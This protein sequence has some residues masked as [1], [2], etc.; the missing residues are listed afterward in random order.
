M[1]YYVRR[2]VDPKDALW[3]VCDTDGRLVCL[4]HTCHEAE[5]EAA[6]LNESAE[7]PDRAAGEGE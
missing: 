7:E 4:C 2:P 1:S 6:R 3:E 5:S